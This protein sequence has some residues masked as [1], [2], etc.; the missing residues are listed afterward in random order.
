LRGDATLFSRWDEV[1][2]SWIFADKIIEYRGQKRFD[3]PNYDAG[4]MG[5]VRAFELLAMDGRKWWEV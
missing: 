2:A 4:T 5:P 1:E 3:Y